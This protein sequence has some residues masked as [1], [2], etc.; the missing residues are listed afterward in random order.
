MKLQR[1]LRAPGTRLDIVAGLVDGI[2]NALILAAGRMLKT[3]GVDL[4]LTL[5]V[6]AAT[7]LTTLF[8]FFVAHYA[9]RR[10]ELAEAERELSLGG[11]GRLVASQLG[12]RA[13]LAAASGAAVAAACGVCGAAGALTV[14]A[15]LPRPRGI[16]LAAVILALALLGALLARSVHGSRLMWAVGVAGGGAILTWIGIQLNI[17]G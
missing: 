13:V 4:A 17:A 9:E 7:G 8:V 6:G 1:W 3:S 11:H 12:R 10:A 16:G 15:L 2:L 14:C 5:R